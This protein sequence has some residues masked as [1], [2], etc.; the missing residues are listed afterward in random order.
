MWEGSIPNQWVRIKGQESFKKLETSS[1]KNQNTLA[2]LEETQKYIH[3]IRKPLNLKPSGNSSYRVLTPSKPRR[4]ELNMSFLD[5]SRGKS[6][7]ENEKTLAHTPTSDLI[8]E[9]DRVIS[10]SPDLK[11]FQPKFNPLNINKNSHRR[12]R[13][14]QDKRSKTRLERTH[15]RSPVKD[16]KEISLQGICMSPDS[17]KNLKSKEFNI[18]PVESPNELTLETQTTKNYQRSLSKRSARVVIS[19]KSPTLL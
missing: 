16:D 2:F 18:Q 14:V 5:R 3:K 4:P 8:T 17:Y 12:L 9:G 13:R 7:F 15:S 10:L 1:A 6:P 11:V 19:K